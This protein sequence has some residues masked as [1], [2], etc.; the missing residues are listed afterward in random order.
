[1]NTFE[2]TLRENI[3][4]EVNT[5]ECTD[6]AMFLRSLL[7]YTF[8]AFSI[9]ITLRGFEFFE[10]SISAL[11]NHFSS[12]FARY[13]LVLSAMAHGWSQA[14]LALYGRTER[15]AK[16]AR[17]SDQVGLRGGLL[18]YSTTSISSRTIAILECMPACRTRPIHPTL[19]SRI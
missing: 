10:L 6:L 15:K 12:A 9:S 11:F 16:K 4:C 13:I 7:L 18:F 5:W 2:K 17:R 19:C 1:M 14:D 8:C 3:W